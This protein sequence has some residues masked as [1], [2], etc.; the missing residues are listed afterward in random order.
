M[1]EMF[2]LLAMPRSGNTL[3]SS[4]MNQ[5]SDI[6]VTA[7]SITP[8]ILKR[9]DLLKKTE[10]FKNFPDHKSL[11]NVLCS[12]YDNYYKDWKCKYIIERS[13]IL[14]RGNKY[15]INKYLKKPFKCII[16]WRDLLDVL[17]SYIKW[18][19]TEPTAFPNKLKNKNMEEKLNFIMSKN[20]A[21][22][23]S[24]NSIENALKEENK[25]MCHF[26]TYDNLVYNTEN[27]IIKIYSFLNIPYFKHNYNKLSQFKVNDISY[28]DSVVGKN[29]HTI[30][31]KIEKQLNPYR[32]KIPE[33]IV[34]K[35]K[36]ICI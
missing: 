15:L 8:E 11:D 16:I 33:S 18:F 19:E 2:F 1:K 34:K 32:D 30:K 14:N 26:L 6:A 22:L 4:I 27:E 28:D 13:A 12:I 17:A 10:T 23:K 35:Y 29:M 7:N 3:F 36:H 24:L 31:I 25:D 9:I 5:N 21:V 20:G